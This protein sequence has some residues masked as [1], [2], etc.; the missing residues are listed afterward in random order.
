MTEIRHYNFDHDI[1]SPTKYL[2]YY[3]WQNSKFVKRVKYAS[4]YIII[5]FQEPISRLLY[6]VGQFLQSTEEE[7]DDILASQTAESG[8]IYLRNKLSNIMKQIC[9][10]RC[11]YLGINMVS[12]TED[13]WKCSAKIAWRRRRTR[14]PLVRR[15]V[16]IFTERFD[17]VVRNL[18]ARRTKITHHLLFVTY[19]KI[20]ASQT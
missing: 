2:D 3:F 19:R 20:L 5:N 18:V 4:R 6:S 1:M 11:D 17:R 12:I 16:K 13:V 14:T 10:S 8:S 9:D 7:D 15:A